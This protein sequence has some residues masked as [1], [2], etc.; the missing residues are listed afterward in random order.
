MDAGNAEVVA[1]SSPMDKIHFSPSSSYEKSVLITLR[2]DRLGVFT[3]LSIPGPAEI[4]ISGY[5]SKY[6][7]RY[8]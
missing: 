5:T 1:V 2:P 6:T 7:P 4:P 8:G 3:M